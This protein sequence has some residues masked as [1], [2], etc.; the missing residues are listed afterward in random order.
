MNRNIGSMIPNSILDCSSAIRR[1]FCPECRLSS[2]APYPK[3]N[4]FPAALIDALSAYHYLINTLGFSPSN[5]VLSGDSAGGHLALSLVRYLVL[6]ASESNNPSTPGVPRALIL[7]SPTCDWGG[8]HDGTPSSAMT[9]NARSDYVSVILNSRYV[10]RA[11]L[12]NLPS[13]DAVTNAWISPASLR[14]PHPDGLF[15][16]FPA[17]FIAAG[18]AEVTL[19][20]MRTLRD[21]VVQDNGDGRVRYL[22]YV[23]ATHDFVG[24]EW[25]QPER[26]DALGELKKWLEEVLV[27]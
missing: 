2:A 3:A 7:L 4:P 5:V 6:S 17:T 16:G 9:R 13:S 23:D 24:L 21:R 19:D 18:G 27:E 22:E 25:H 8:T 10:P 20:G 15:G 14:I 26:G 1:A 11:L 12:G